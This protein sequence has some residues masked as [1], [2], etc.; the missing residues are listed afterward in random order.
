MNWFLTDEADRNYSIAVFDALGSRE[1]LVPSLWI[2]E[3][4][5]VLLVAHRRSR[6][7]KER[8]EDILQ[9]VIGFNLR[10]DAVTA[11]LA[12]DLSRL[13]L[14]YGLTVYDAAYLDLAIRVGAPIATKDK[15]LLS[16]MAAVNVPLV[17]V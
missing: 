14:Q 4:S 9:I 15:A 17:T 16:A 12:L 5:N 1:I 3:V 8:I 11:G 6:I 7:P 10:I 2:Y 13:G